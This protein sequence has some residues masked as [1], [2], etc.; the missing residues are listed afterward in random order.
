[1]AESMQGLLPPRRCRV[2]VSNSGSR[3]PSSHALFQSRGYSSSNSVDFYLQSPSWA[4]ARPQESEAGSESPGWQRDKA[5][6]E[7]TGKRG[8]PSEESIQQHQGDLPCETSQVEDFNIVDV[9]VH[10]GWRE[11]TTC[12]ARMCLIGQ[13]AHEHRSI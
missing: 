2:L 12:E 6:H 11:G 7:R 13:D 3:L 8:G 1:M 10:Y 9:D 5:A 4:L